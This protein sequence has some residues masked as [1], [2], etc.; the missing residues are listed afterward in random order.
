MAESLDRLQ[1]KCT[2][3]KGDKNNTILKNYWNKRETGYNM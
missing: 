1:N 2:H 3:C